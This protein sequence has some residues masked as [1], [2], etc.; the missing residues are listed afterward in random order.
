MLSL[1]GMQKIAVHW[2]VRVHKHGA[3]RAHRIRSLWVSSSA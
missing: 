1:P 2:K 3:Q